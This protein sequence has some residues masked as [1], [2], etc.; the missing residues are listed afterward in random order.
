MRLIRPAWTLCALPLL[1]HP[2]AVPAA[3]Q[4]P[5]CRSAGWEVAERY[6]VEG[7]DDRRFTHEQYW[8]ALAPAFD[9]DRIGLTRLGESLEGRAI[10]AVTLGSGPVTVLLW[11]QMHGDESTASMSLADLVNWF[12]SAPAADTL[13]QTLADRL[14]ITMIPMLN[15]D[16]AERFVREN[17]VGIDI[18][19]D[20]RRTATPEGRILRGV[21]DSIEADFG[22][23]LHDQGTRTAGEDGP[24]VAIALLAPAADEERSWGPVRQSARQVAAVIA[25]TLEPDLGQRMARYDDEFTPRAFGDNMQ[26]WGT[27]TVLIE[28]GLLAGDPQKQELRKL[29]VVAL[30]SALHA[31]ATGEY[32][33]H[34]TEAYDELPMNLSLS[35]D[36]LLLG[37]ELILG[38]GEPIR[39][40]VAIRYE[41]AVARTG[42]RYGEIGDLADVAAVDTLDVTEMLLH[43]EP[44][45]DGTIR[46][47]EAAVLTV[48]R[49]READSDPVWSIGKRD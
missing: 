4:E 7:L 24:V 19:R 12:A 42:P 37:G 32:E 20:A 8:K 41:D 14:T 21:R 27:S 17:R 3:A 5:C 49:G 29:N 36:L 26:L 23:N 33:D 44:G 38:G 2:F 31:I 9:S 30:L 43:A 16:G 11:S 35:N 1:A 47:G 48:R 6:R 22:F 46:A 15:P 25:A 45:S 28:S 34:S 40:D 13:R 10:N 39:A 18:N